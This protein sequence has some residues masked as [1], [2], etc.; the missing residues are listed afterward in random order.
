ME[1]VIITGLSGAGKSEAVDF[2]EDHGFFCID[3]LP[4]QL[5]KTFVELCQ[6]SD[7]TRLALVT[8]IRAESFSKSFEES[9]LGFLRDNDSARLLFLDA[10]D[11]TLISRFQQTRRRHP[12][13][14]TEGS[15][16]N[17]IATE[18]KILHPFRKAADNVI[19]TSGLKPAQLK[20]QLAEDF[21][22]QK[23]DRL[24]QINILSFGFKYGPPRSADFAFDARFLPNPFYKDELRFKTGEDE[25]VRNYVMQSDVAKTYLERITQLLTDIIPS[26]L[27]VDKTHMTVAFGCTGGQHRSVTFAVL[28]AEAFKRMGYP[29]TLRHRDILKDRTRD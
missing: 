23:N 16:E 20:E 2:F 26:Y 13:T 22:Q 28:L 15:L 4:P 12:L 25:E 27:E 1:T 3:N 9:F 14:E 19:D 8:D 21:D 5:I 6:G 24:M 18:R 29:V 10:D 11:D 17:A 7:I